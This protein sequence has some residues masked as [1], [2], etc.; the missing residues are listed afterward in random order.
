MNTKK[1]MLSIDIL[2]DLE[3]HSAKQQQPPMD[4][5]VVAASPSGRISI[6][7]G[8][9]LL[10]WTSWLT[11]DEFYTQANNLA[12]VLDSSPTE[13]YVW[14]TPLNEPVLVRRASIAV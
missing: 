9:E 5:L 12:Q 11:I 4:Q 1:I 7:Q 13:V 6:F 2:D 10:D 14:V 3:W 8:R